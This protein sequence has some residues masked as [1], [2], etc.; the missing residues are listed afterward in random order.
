MIACSATHRF[1]PKPLPRGSPHLALDAAEMVPV[2][3]FVY[4][5]AN[6]LWY[7]GEGDWKNAVLSGV[8]AVPRVV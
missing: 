5:G 6:A 4:D 7:A 8:A 1:R 3:S 2:V